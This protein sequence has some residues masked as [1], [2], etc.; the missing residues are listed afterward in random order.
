VKRIE[1]RLR[2][3]RRRISRGRWRWSGWRNLLRPIGSD[4]CEQQS[5]IKNGRQ[6]S[7]VLRR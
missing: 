2:R 5:R 4:A 3:C 7:H 6:Q 1:H